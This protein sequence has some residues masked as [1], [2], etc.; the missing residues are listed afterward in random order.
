MPRDSG[1]SIYT[2]EKIR[3]VV[4]NE[5]NKDK[6]A[7]KPSPDVIRPK[8]KE[9]KASNYRKEKIPKEPR[10]KVKKLKRE[11]IVAKKRC[12]SAKKKK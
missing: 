12:R 4:D 10:K 1:T 9:S 6:V 2:Y 11:E 3:D 8:T 5:E 7:P